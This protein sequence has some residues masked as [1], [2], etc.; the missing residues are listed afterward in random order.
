MILVADTFYHSCL[1][2]NP[3]RKGREDKIIMHGKDYNSNLSASYVFYFVVVKIH[4]IAST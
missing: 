2:I 3:T 1:L 4:R